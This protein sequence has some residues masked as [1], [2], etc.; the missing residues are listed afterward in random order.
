MT[1]YNVM[2][3]GQYWSMWWL[4]CCLESYSFKFTAISLR[5]E[6]VNEP[7]D[8]MA[9]YGVINLSQHWRRWKLAAH[10][11]AR[12]TINQCPCIVNSTSENKLH[13]NSNQNSK[14]HIYE[15][16]LEKVLCKM[17][18]ILFRTYIGCRSPWWYGSLDENETLSLLL[19]ALVS[20]LLI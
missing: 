5:G 15:N 9:A 7:N 12:H 10:S 2:E 3:L 14:C 4:V 11:M 1:S 16:E 8:L 20:V 6:R 18:V 19:A 17:W 13:S